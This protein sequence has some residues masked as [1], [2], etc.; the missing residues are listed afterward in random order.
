[1]EYQQAEN[2][3]N[4]SANLL[5]DETALFQQY[6]YASTGQ[7]FLN[8]LIENRFMNYGLSYA[9]G[10][11]IG[12]LLTMINPEFL[13]VVSSGS[14]YLL[15]IAYCI[16]LLNFSLYYF[17]CEKFLHVYTLGKIITGTKAIREDGNPLTIKIFY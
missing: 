12:L 8:F 4:S 15:L 16:S 5:G 9:T 17:F 14:A 13:N 3:E 11:A 10:Y 1:M 2:S 6:Q 7:R